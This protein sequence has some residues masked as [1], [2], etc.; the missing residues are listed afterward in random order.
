MHYVKGTQRV[1]V[2]CPKSVIPVWYLE[3]PK[4][5]NNW[6]FVDKDS[7][8]KKGLIS[9]YVTNYEQLLNDP[10]LYDIR[11]WLEQDP[12]SVVIC[13][14][15][16]KIKNPTAQRSKRVH[17]LTDVS[18][19]RVFMT[20]TPISK[21][22]LDLF[23]QFKF[24]DPSIF[25]TTWTAFKRQYA[26]FGGYG[27]HQVLRY[28]NLKTLRKKIK[29]YVFQARKEDC[30]D[31]PPKTHEI[32]PVELDRSDEVYRH[33]ARESIV[34]FDGL[35]VETPIVL[36]RML[37]LSQLT[38]GWLKGED[39]YRRVGTEKLDTFRGLLTE[40][41]EQD[42]KKVVVFCRFLKELADIAKVGKELGYK[43]IPYYGAVGTHEREQRVAFFE[44]SEDRCL[45]VAQISTGALGITLVSA[46]EAI[47]YSHTYNYAE[48]VQACDRLHRIGQTRRVT[49]Y[50]LLAQGTVDETVWLAL[51]TK[52]DVADLVLRHPEL[53]AGP[54]G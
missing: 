33:L 31:L 15:S 32:V 21:N 16:H 27:G 54:R 45:F 22:P 37:R 20:G 42:R 41:A 10:R 12:A 1:L 47:F 6:R 14:E 38:G 4:H 18:G 51:K 8:D 13:D 34:E 9:W 44:E 49:Y 46:S 48:F 30:L 3:V 43:V 50:H 23:S 2:L 11:L 28:I 24:F 36:T 29:P 53:M 52:Q 39:G 40:M 26:L 35:E 25:G 19:M 7:R 17:G 5:S